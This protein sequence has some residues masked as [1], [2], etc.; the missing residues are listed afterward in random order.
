M[1]SFLKFQVHLISL[2][3]CNQDVQVKVKE[4]VENKPIISEYESL[5][6]HY[7]VSLLP[8]FSCLEWFNLSVI[9]KPNSTNIG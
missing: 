7:T 6:R 4:F 2:I 8:W 9:N 3:C 1:K 5:F